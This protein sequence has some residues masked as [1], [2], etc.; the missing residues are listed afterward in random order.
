MRQDTTQSAGA[1]CV[2]GVRGQPR[3][4]GK[5]SIG[6]RARI[7]G[8]TVRHADIR[9]ICGHKLHGSVRTPDQPSGNLLVWR[10]LNAARTGETRRAQVQQ[11]ITWYRRGIVKV[12]VS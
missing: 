8:W 6:V 2:R 3:F 1:W 9:D 11:I 5:G 4:D 10:V 12:M 7:D